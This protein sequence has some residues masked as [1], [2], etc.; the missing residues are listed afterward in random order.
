MQMASLTADRLST[1]TVFSVSP[2]FRG[3]S[4]LPW[5]GDA[6]GAVLLLTFLLMLVL[7]GLAL[8]AGAASHSSI[9]GVRGQLLDRQAFYVAEAG[10]QRARQAVVAGAWTAASSP[11]NSYAESFG[12]GAYQV[13]VVDNGGGSY[14][15]TA[16]GYVPTQADYQARRRLVESQL[17]VTASDGTNYSLGATAS[18]STSNGS[19]TPDKAK[20]GSTSTKWQAGSNGNGWLAM[21]YSSATTLNKVVVK[22][23]GNI[24]GVSIEWSDN[25]SSWTSASGQSVIESPGNTWTATF[26]AASHRYVRASVSAASNKK[27]AV[28]ELESYH[29]AISSLGAGSVT[30]QW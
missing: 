18:A 22:E 17:S 20:D 26:T 5:C 28:K 13:T 4:V 21:D 25:G 14:T 7:A 24:T 19:N 12:P 23:D 3:H 6:R 30:T 9:M 2:C 10:W 8:A 16:D 15:M 29:S 1:Q 27:P 11:G